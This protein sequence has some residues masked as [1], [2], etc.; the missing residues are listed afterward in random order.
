MKKRIAS[1]HFLLILILM[2]LLTPLISSS[3]AYPVVNDKNLKVEVVASGLKFP[4]SMTFLGKND[5]LVLEKN[6]GTV[7][8]IVNGTI[9]TNPLLDV[10]VANKNERGLLGIASQDNKSD[11]GRIA[12][13]Y[14][15][16]TESMMGDGDDFGEGQTPLANRLYR[17]ELVGN[18]LVNPV[19]LL[20]LPAHPGPGHNSGKVTIGP[21]NN[22]YVVVGDLGGHTKSQNII[23]GSIPDG[24]GG[25][26]RVTQDGDKLEGILG[27][28]YP[29]DLYYAY[30]IRNSFGIAF[31]PV[32]G[33]LWDTENGEYFG[34]EVNLVEPG[35]NSGWSKVQGVWNA[36][37]AERAQIESDPTKS[38]VTF[39]GN[40]KY[41]PP[42][43]TWKKP[44]GVTALSFF[45]S[46]KLGKQYENDL[47]VG[48]FH[49]GRLYDF[50]LNK[51][52]TYFVLNDELSD[53]IA[54]TEE[55]QQQLIFGN[56]FGA[57]T[58]IQLGPDGYLYI[59]SVPTGG[60]DCLWVKNG[61]R[62]CTSYNSE[63]SG[64]VFRI[65]PVKI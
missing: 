32:T 6:E 12:N 62:P 54:D 31:D 52:R 58:D 38:L 48:D 35:F 60:D 23:N 7:K 65:V 47:F 45:D 1:T 26:L 13:V 30:G 28:E 4:T 19:L 8:R 43:F 15:Y 33:N 27:K 50:D 25:I 59:L 24:R 36:E 5:I 2:V 14:L 11:N 64:T 21:D 39:N 61:T 41:G 57:I 17:Y 29:F 37:I 40:G 46:G 10:N 22:V 16:F 34:D 53:G 9:L 42:K 63:L 49:K 18:I 44:I 51:D 56:G 20:N 55:E 3:M